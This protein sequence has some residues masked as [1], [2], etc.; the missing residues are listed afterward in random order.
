MADS[1]DDQMESLPRKRLLVV[2]LWGIGDLVF[3]TT[4]L[5]KAAQQFEVTLLAKPHA[6]PLLARTLPEVRHIAWDAPWTAY[7]GKYRW[8]SWDWPALLGTMRALRKHSFDA[9]VS[10][11]DDPR[12]HLLMRLAGARRRIGFPARGSGALLTDEM[13]RVPGTQHKVEDWRM[14]AE[15]LEIDGAASA[16]PSLAADRPA[17]GIAPRLC[18]HVGARIP[19]RRWPAANFADLIRRL[20]EK[21]TAHLTIVPDSDGYGRELAPLA[22]DFVEEINLEGLINLLAASDALICNDSGPGHLA[23]AVG[24]PVA[25]VFGPTDPV[26]Y[27]PWGEGHR[28]VIRDICPHR[29]CFDYCKFPEPYCLTRLTP[30]EVWPEFEKFLT[31]ILSPSQMMHLGKRN[32]LGI[33]IDAID[34]ESATG[35]I[36]AAAREGR[37]FS[38]SALAVHG[39]MTG[40][41]DP[42]QRYRL[43][44]FDLLCPDGQPVRWMLNALHDAVLVDR[45]YGPFLTLRVCEA[46]AREGLG[47]FLFGGTPGTL[48]ALADNLRRQFPSLIIAASQASRFRQATPDEV[49]DDVRAIRESGA[50]L[51]LC[52]IGCPRQEVWAYEMRDR[53]SMPVLAV[54][55]AFDFLSGAKPMAP[56]WMQ[57][58]GLEWLHRLAAEPR[59][60]WHRYLVQ[61]PRFVWHATRQLLFHQRY[62]PADGR[63]P[64]AEGNFG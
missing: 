42:E 34:Y 48:A 2:E 59:R 28:V 8:W 45:V 25:A 57:S 35:Q 50:K 30:D 37:G 43:N 36:L 23:A 52:G 19:V 33:Q 16:G 38:V 63:P 14:L 51:C 64:T 55:A 58:A 18:L 49:A 20:R 26:R 7:R 62:D 10:V 47:I 21:F 5:R 44:H 31:P 24:T 9:A 60:L 56:R 27:R 54:G 29:P 46:A 40:V 11:R 39:V 6:Q 22:D 1:P 12:D 3:A 61:N 13:H 4:L 17:R 53:L 32:V 15:R 41:D